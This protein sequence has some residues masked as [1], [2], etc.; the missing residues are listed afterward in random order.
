MT[1]FLICLLACL[2][3]IALMAVGVMMGREPLKGTCGGLNRLGFKDDECPVCGG[4]FSK[5][6]SQSG[7]GGSP[8]AKAASL[9][10][11][12]SRPASKS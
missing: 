3:F 1:L 6:D 4:D 5:C 7:Q 2:L 9:A 8:N 12:A 11:D 10:Y